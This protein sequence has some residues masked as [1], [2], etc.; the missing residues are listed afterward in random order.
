M[1]AVGG[2]AWYHQI[3]DLTADDDNL[4]DEM[5][6]K[7]T[8]NPQG[9]RDLPRRGDGVLLFSGDGQADS[10]LGFCGGFLNGRS[11]FFRLVEGGSYGFAEG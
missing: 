4:L 3:P 11:F 7:A 2:G 9:I 6:P 1:I 8:K 5:P 10:R